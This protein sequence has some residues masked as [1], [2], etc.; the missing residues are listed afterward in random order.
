MF[1][2]KFDIKGS[3][4]I[5][6][7]LEVASG[8]L[9]EVCIIV[10]KEKGITITAMDL[11]HICL[12]HLQFS[13]KDCLVFEGPEE[14]FEFAVNLIDLGKILRRLSAGELFEMKIPLEEKQLSLQM[15]KEGQKKVRSFKLGLM[16]VDKEEINLAGLLETA[17]TYPNSFSLD[18]DLLIEAIG[19]AE[20][21]AEALRLTVS[22]KLKF[23]ADGNIGDME[24]EIEFD[25]LSEAKITEKTDGIFA[26]SFLKNILKASTITKDMSLKLVDQGPL[27]ITFNIT[28]DSHMIFFLAPRV[29][30]DDFMDDEN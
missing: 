27:F 3:A 30:D 26:I 22:D 15:R 6:K 12:V 10:Q 20:I 21:Y 13:P 7:S 18:V 14:E 8:I 4:L 25:E 24:Y 19:D 9:H 11:S 17:V 28:G 1:E 23:S 16:D 29:E 2:A 5:K